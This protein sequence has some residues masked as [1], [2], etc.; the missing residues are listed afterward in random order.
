MFRDTFPARRLVLLAAL[1]ALLVAPAGVAAQG[2]QPVRYVVVLSFDGLRP[3]ALRPIMPAALLERAAY[4]W[5]AQTT[6]PSVT[7]PAHTSMLTGV[8]PSVHRQL[9]NS[10]DSR[11]AHVQVP[12]AFSVVTESGGRSAMVVTKEKL[13]YLARPGTVAW[14]E[15]LPYPRHDQTEAVRVAMRYLTG[16]QPHLLFI[17]LADPDAVGHR[18]GWMSASYLDVARKVPATIGLVL[19]TLVRMGARARSLVIVT[20]DH[21]GHGRTH[22]SKSREDMTIPWLAFGAVPPGALAQSVTTYDTAATAVAALGYAI[23]KSWFGRPV[24]KT[25]GVRP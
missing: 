1:V 15:L 21:G 2:V 9:A 7:L 13:F 10:W 23:P 19:D 11:Q 12:T 17:H 6:F 24:I 4:T 18:D 20:A 25:A 3:D 8:P 22:G 5:E 14:A 16:A